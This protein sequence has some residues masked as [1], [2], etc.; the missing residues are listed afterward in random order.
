MVRVKSPARNKFPRPR[1]WPGVHPVAGNSTCNPDS[2]KRELSS[3]RSIDSLSNFLV[4]L[5][6]AYISLHQNAQELG[7]SLKIRSG[8]ETGVRPKVQSTLNR[9]ATCTL[10]F[11]P[12]VSKYLISSHSPAPNPS[13]FQ[14]K[15]SSEFP[16]RREFEDVSFLNVSAMEV[17]QHRSLAQ[18]DRPLSYEL[19]NA[20]PTWAGSNR[21]TRGVPHWSAPF[22]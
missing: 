14:K 8:N 21:R 4:F 15:K 12:D 16:P 1:R 17:S 19:H 2:A 6:P 10:I 9:S 11:S 3:Y 13:F 20:G 18:L 5:S 22:R 7:E